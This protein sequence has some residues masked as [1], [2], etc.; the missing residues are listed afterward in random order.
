MRVFPHLEGKRKSGAI[1]NSHFFPSPKETLNDLDIIQYRR[2]TNPLFL[3]N[4]SKRFFL[5][6]PHLQYGQMRLAM[7]QHQ[8]F[9][10]LES[11]WF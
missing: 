2:L 6:S 4:L 7:F 9:R 1:C 3:K 10:L 11:E 8:A 5:S